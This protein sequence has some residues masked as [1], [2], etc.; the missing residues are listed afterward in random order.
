PTQYKETQCTAQE[1]LA[2][3]TIEKMVGEIGNIQSNDGYISKLNFHN[4]KSPRITEALSFLPMFTQLQHLDCSYASI[5]E[6]PKLPDGL[7]MLYCFH[8][9]ITELLKL[10]NGLR[11]LSCHNTSIT[12]LLK[13]PNGLRV[14]Y[15]D[16]TSITELPK[17]PDSL[18]QINITNTPASKDPKIQQQLKTFQQTHP[19]AV[20]TS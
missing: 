1:Y 12:E 16:N 17:L 7:Q 4:N 2:L 9:S 3:E 11:V 6:L 8:T 18:I 20:V 5:T 13:L 19:G 14:F 10:P 15:C